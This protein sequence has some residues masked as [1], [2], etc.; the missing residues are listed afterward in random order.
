MARSVGSGMSLPSV[1]IG[2]V[3]LR[4]SR[5]VKAVH[6]DACLIVRHG[7]YP[8]TA[9]ELSSAAACLVAAD[10]GY[11]CELSAD[12]NQ[13]CNSSQSLHHAT[14]ADVS[15][16]STRTVIGPVEQ[17][18]EEAIHIAEDSLHERAALCDS[19]LPDPD[20]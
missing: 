17:S 6:A 2:K 11:T 16:A 7:L 9:A 20:M 10:S 1:A 14:A 8:A 15:V 18:V 3:I 12:N 4:L 5:Q 19:G 13:F